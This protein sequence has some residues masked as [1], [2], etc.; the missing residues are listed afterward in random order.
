MKTTQC[1]CTE[2]GYCQRHDITKSKILFGLCQNKQ[3]YF[4]AWEQGRGPGQS[5]PKLPRPDQEVL[6][7]DMISKGKRYI[8]ERATWKK[9]GKPVRSDESIE[10]IFTEQCV[11]CDFF[12]KRSDT[13]GQCNICG[14]FLKPKGLSFN[15]IAWATAQCPLERPKWK[16]DVEISPKQEQELWQ[17]QEAKQQE[18]LKTKDAISSTPPPSPPPK[19]RGCCHQ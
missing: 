5:L 18:G 8:E 1:E 14:C 19:R 12:H 16:A 10:Q 2:P 17:E 4:D 11:K 15:K 13:L 6:P 3:K 9:A 7:Q